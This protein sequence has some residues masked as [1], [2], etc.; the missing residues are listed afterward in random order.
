MK[1]T[2]FR[3]SETTRQLYRK[4]PLNEHKGFTSVPDGTETIAYETIVDLAALDEMAR[5]A[6][7]SKSQKSKDGALTVK[8]IERKK[9]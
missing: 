8:I 1:R 6:A 9:L 7:A 3:R 5:R 4:E 2:I